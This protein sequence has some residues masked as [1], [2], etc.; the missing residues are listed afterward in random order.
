MTGSET[1]RKQL[2]GVQWNGEQDEEVWRLSK[3]RKESTRSP[4]DRFS[5]YGV[6]LYQTDSYHH[7]FPAVIRT[8]IYLN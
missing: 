3:M 7:V 8:T 6:L 2:R 1:K 4:L 5:A